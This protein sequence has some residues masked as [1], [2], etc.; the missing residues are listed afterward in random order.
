MGRIAGNFGKTE[1]HFHENCWHDD[2]I[3]EN[4]NTTS[5]N[6]NSI[7]KYLMRA[8]IRNLLNDKHK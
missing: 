4:Q 7:T 5:N 2:C 6:Y 8:C 1:I 3:E